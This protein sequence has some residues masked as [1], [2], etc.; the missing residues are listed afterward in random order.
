MDINLHN[1]PPQRRSQ[2]A[3]K[4]LYLDGA[5]FSLNDYPFLVDVYDGCYQGM[6]LKTARQISKTLYID[7]DILYENGNVRKLDNVQLGDRVVGL[8]QDTA[9]TDIGIVSW[10]SERYE[11][12]CVK[13]T[14]RQGHSIIAGIEH[15]MRTWDSWTPAGKLKIKDRLAVMRQGSI[16][17]GTET[18]SDAWITIAACMIAE[19]S[20]CGTPSFTQCE[21]ELLDDFLYAIK[22][23][24]GWFIPCK[25]ISPGGYI[26]QLCF[27]KNDAGEENPVRIKLK[28]WGIYGKRS[29]QLHIPSF[30][31]NLNREQTAL[32]L[33]R[34]WAGDGNAV[35][36]KSCYHI[37]Y[38][39]ISNKLIHDVQ[40]LLWKF[41]IPSNINREKPKVYEG[42]DKWA[43]TLRIE[44]QDGAFRFIDQIGALGK[45]ENLPLLNVSDNSN[46]D[47]YP[48]AIEKNLQ[49][50]NKSRKGYKQSGRF[51]PQPSLYSVGLRK[52]LPYPPSRRKLQQYIS[53]FRNKEFDQA[54]VDNLTAHLDTD[55]F[56][57][58]IT[59][60]EDVGI[61][62]CKDITVD[63]TQSFVGNAFITHNSTTLCNFILSESIGIPHFRSLYISPSQE[64]T[65]TFSN[66]R[67]GKTVYYS[68]LVRKY[69]STSDFT[70]RTMLRMFRNGSEIKFTYAQDD[71]DRARG[72]TADR[73][74]FD[75]VQD[76]LYDD[77]IPVITECS[78]NSNY[79]YETYAGTPKTM[80]NTIEYLWSISTQT[81]WIMQCEGC[82]KWNFIE[83]EKSIGKTGPI[84]L[85]CGHLLNPRDGQ[86]Y[87]FNPSASLKGFHVAQP[88]LPLNSEDPER[89]ERILRKLERYSETKL[90]NEVFGVSD[91]L[92][93]RL[94]SKEELYALCRTYDIY[95]TPPRNMEIF[96]HIV[97]GV[98]WSGG[99]TEGVSRTVLWIFGITATH[100]LKTLFFRIYPVTNPVSIV[101]DVAEILTNYN[102]S[103]TVG[104]R[105]EGH[106]A[107]NQLKQ[108]LGRHRVTQ[109]KYGAQASPITW[110]EDADSY[111]ADRTT[112]M[113]NYFM[114]LKRGGVIYP[115]ENYMAVPIQDTLN[116][117][118]EVTQSGLKVWR[119]APTK[120]DDAFHAQLFAW[121]AAKIVLM[122]ME[123]AG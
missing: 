90:K 59:A 37:N 80:E 24:G 40:Q 111:H 29:A 54:L 77:V 38:G 43:Y 94:I 81:E 7:T 88:I 113:D 92:G 15:P 64:Q 20:N 118:E 119:H 53:F 68:P 61:Q 107:N 52:T 19:G 17:T 51:A 76:I 86:W 14:T 89:W 100:Q 65:Q 27:V 74:N 70:H 122:D 79:G 101:D 69:W 91:A 66:T 114:V 1:I 49:D 117:Y 116:I 75:E 112:L 45:T 34:L 35:L 83:S 102:V 33:N 93:T 106:L 6:L 50:I 9:H 85:S 105:G 57:D 22:Q 28:E 4:L 60:I 99:G 123:F 10:I 96:S 72:N 56:W 121:I 26:W 67:I 62:S 82:N 63:N 12:P 110:N 58:E 48:I 103:L 44:T 55:L 46:R 98:D 41:G 39:S 42:T 16:F 73:V 84:C 23:I 108:K 78:A 21:N 109:V 25:R 36:N 95:R 32:F 97:A 71:P 18:E 120:P 2:L 115:N 31:W 13:I 87:N 3:Q 104:D 30:V 5:P 47:T 8:A 11:K